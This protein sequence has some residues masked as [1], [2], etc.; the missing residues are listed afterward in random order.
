MSC[1]ESFIRIRLWIH[2]SHSSHNNLSPI[3]TSYSLGIVCNG[4]MIL[5]FHTWIWL[6]RKCQ[7][8]LKEILYGNRG[9]WSTSKFELRENDSSALKCMCCKISSG[10]KEKSS[11]D[12]WYIYT[13]M[14]YGVQHLARSWPG[15]MTRGK[16]KK[17]KPWMFLACSVKT[18][19][20]AYAIFLLSFPVEPSI[21]LMAPGEHEDKVDTREWRTTTLQI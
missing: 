17:N 13:I 2:F 7:G 15:P 12:T 11:V 6:S 18:S 21:S 3:N 8:F 5:Y 14:V 9:N 16:K 19:L 10:R 1:M 20:P 4:L